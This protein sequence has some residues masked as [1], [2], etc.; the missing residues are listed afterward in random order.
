[1]QG[2]IRVSAGEIFGAISELAR[3]HVG[4][5][6]L[7]AGFMTV[8]QVI[9]DL[10]LGEGEGVAFGTFIAG[11]VNFFVTY[12]VTEQILRSEGL[13]TVWSRSYGAMFGANILTTLGVGL[14]FVLLFVPGLYL[15]ARWSMVSPIIVAEGVTASQ[16]LSRSWEATRSS[17]W[18]I[19]VVY[20][21]YVLFFVMLLGGIGVASAATGAEGQGVASSLVINGAGS[22]LGIAGILIAVAVY[23][24]LAAGGAQ[25]EDVFA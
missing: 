5:C 10:V 23:R 17:V 22:L 21:A 18:S 3:R 11:I 12:R 13:M 19:A 20:L 15:L 8:L 2:Q 9:L 4:V 14:G 24:S 6:A 25:Y 1:M 16:A 7:A